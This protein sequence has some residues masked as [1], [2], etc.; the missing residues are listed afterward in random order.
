MKFKNANFDIK[1]YKIGNKFYDIAIPYK[2]SKCWTLSQSIAIGPMLREE[3]ARELPIHRQFFTK[4]LSFILEIFAHFLQIDKAIF[5]KHYGFSTCLFE[6]NEIKQIIENIS[7]L[8]LEFPNHAIILRSI[9]KNQITN[10]NHNAKPI[11]SR[12]IWVL[13][14]VK[15][16]WQNRT[17]VKRDLQLIEK[18]NLQYVIYDNAISDEKLQKCIKL[19]NQIYIEKYSKFNPQ[20]NEKFLRFLLKEKILSLHCL[21][22][23]NKI[24]AFC[25][26]YIDDMQ[27]TSPML[28]YE[29]CDI[30]LYRAIMIIAPQIA[31]EKNLKLNLSSGANVFKKNRGARPMLEYYLVIDSHLPFWRKI[32]FS[33][34]QKI[35]N[36]F[37]GEL[38]KMAQ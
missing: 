3:I 28:G 22:K 14:D 4:I 10:I 12:L 26:I 7:N 15:K 21:E 8:K 9:Q 18:Y 19:Y 38:S 1:K 20:I 35:L 37:E 24:M 23:D 13:N 25:T 36:L 27:I 30:P 33:F 16:D 17:D 31:I 29:I 34:F 6:E 11:I 5:I 32:G 2:N